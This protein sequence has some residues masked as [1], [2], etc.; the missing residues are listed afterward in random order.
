[1][2]RRRFL[3]L[4]SL[5]IMTAGCSSDTNPTPS[6]TPSIRRTAA[7]ESSSPTQYSQSV[8]LTVSDEQW[9]MDGE[10]I[11]CFVSNQ[12]EVAARPAKLVVQWYDSNQ[13]YLGQSTAIVP[14][15]A[16][17][18]IWYPAVEQNEYFDVDNFS[19]SAYGLLSQ[20]NGPDDIVIQSSEIDESI[21]AITGL[22]KNNRPSSA[23][24]SISASVYDSSFLTH[25][26]TSS[27]SNIPS[28]AEWRYIIP[29]EEA[30]SDDS[31]V[32]ERIEIWV[33]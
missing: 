27:E 13:N 3:T 1:M 32:G 24:V 11:E 9:K 6:E 29:L 20:Q 22:V 19:V 16:P 33:S 21:P 30:R 7:T 2:N 23:S 5:S 18:S 25:V 26:G 17:D 31:T 8:E 14:S 12:D 15:L 28:D 4:T 10:V